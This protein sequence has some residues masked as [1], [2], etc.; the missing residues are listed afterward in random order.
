MND[1]AKLD[2]LLADRGNLSY[3]P[4]KGLETVTLVPGDRQ[5]GD[6]QHKSILRPDH[7]LD[8]TTITDIPDG[9]YP[10]IPPA[11]FEWKWFQSARTRAQ[12]AHALKTSKLFY[13]EFHPA[14]MRKVPQDLLYSRAMAWYLVTRIGGDVPI[15]VRLADLADLSSEAP[16]RDETIPASELLTDSQKAMLSLRNSY[17]VNFKAIGLRILRAH[18][19]RTPTDVSEVATSLKPKVGRILK[20]LSKEAYGENSRHLWASHASWL[21]AFFQFCESSDRQRIVLFREISASEE[22]T[23]I[24]ASLGKNIVGGSFIDPERGQ[25]LRGRYILEPILDMVARGFIEADLDRQTFSLTDNGF[26]LLQALA[27][28]KEDFRYFALV[29]KDRD[30]VDAARLDEAHAWIIEFFTKAKGIAD[31]TESRENA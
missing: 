11:I 31:R 13:D 7:L 10:F 4:E 25:L 27:P 24:S 8:E 16:A 19:P 17:M 5:P 12:A 6:A 20:W 1:T 9:A 26:Q 18:M 30:E 23:R 29:D 22:V 21:T 2:T 14:A 3:D 15:K 28:L